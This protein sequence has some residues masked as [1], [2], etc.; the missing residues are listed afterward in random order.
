MLFRS[1]DIT[2]AAAALLLLA[3]LLLLVAVVVKLD[4]PGPVFFRQ[5][6]VGR[7]G[8]PFRIHKFRSMR[9]GAGGGSWACSREGLVM[10]GC[11]AGD[12]NGASRACD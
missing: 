2:F 9:S 11:P 8:V 6:R 7:H 5:E 1:F 3:P 10:E 4:S 12:G